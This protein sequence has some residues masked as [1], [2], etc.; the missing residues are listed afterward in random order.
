MHI[1]EY[2]T[3][4]SSLHI[5]QKKMIAYTWKKNWV[6]SFSFALGPK[7]VMN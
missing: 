7:D 4:G 2:N 1:Q 3:T 5:S 6:S